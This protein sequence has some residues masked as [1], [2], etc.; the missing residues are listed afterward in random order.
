MSTERELIE[1]LRAIADAARAH[2]TA[3]YKTVPR[4]WM[5]ALRDAD[6]YLAGPAASVDGD[7]QPTSENVNALP[8]PIRRY[9]HELETDADPAGTIRAKCILEDQV[10]QLAA[11][12]GGAQAA[13]RRAEYQRDLA[14][15]E[16][17]A[18]FRATDDCCHGH[19]DKARIIARR[20]FE[21]ERG[22]APAAPAPDP[23]ALGGCR[24]CSDCA[25]ERHHWTEDPRVTD[26]SDWACRHCDVRGVSC[27]DCE[28]EEREDCDLCGGCGVVEIAEYIP[29]PAPG[30]EEGG[31]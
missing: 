7:W 30:G 14:A 6:A 3:E 19:A 27:P 29:E 24:R 20:D 2:R 12:L 25:G 1:R 5:D 8:D 16:R 9:I 18:I 13:T 4:A 26:P 17:D 10:K 21:K 22:A 28:L 31:R 15:E 11:Q 23:A